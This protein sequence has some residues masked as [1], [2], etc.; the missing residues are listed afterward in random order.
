MELKDRL[1]AAFEKRSKDPMTTSIDDY[2]TNDIIAP[3]AAKKP[4]VAPAANPAAKK[5][6]VAPA[7]KKPAADPAAKKPAVDNTAAPD[8]KAQPSMWDQVSNYMTTPSKGRNAL[9]GAGIGGLSGAGLQYMRGGD[10]LPGAL[11]GA[12][13]GGYAG[14]ENDNIMKYINKMLGPKAVTMNTPQGTTGAPAATATKKI[15]G[16]DG[17]QAEVTRYP[18]KGKSYVNPDGATTKV[19]PVIGMDEDGQE[20]TM[21]TY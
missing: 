14:Y 20:I 1:E 10:M 12:G 11:I 9:I 7:A 17:Q 2:N 5:P 4:A 16:N 6:P 8:A 19:G 15:T 3:P 18:D 13:L 21:P